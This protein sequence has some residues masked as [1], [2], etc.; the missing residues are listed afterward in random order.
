LGNRIHLLR[1][2]A[3]ALEFVFCEG[4]YSNRR[5]SGARQVVLLDLKLPKVPGLE[6]LKRLKSDPRSR[7][8]PVLVL[9]GSQKESDAVESRQLGA[10]GYI[11]KPVDF[12]KFGTAMP[13]VGLHWLLVSRPGS[14]TTTRS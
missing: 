6:V 3:E 12:E 1:D 10:D 7:Q 2:G 9:T 8:I 13:R 11:V 14:E 4:R 5:P